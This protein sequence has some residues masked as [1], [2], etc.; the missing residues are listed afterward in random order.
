MRGVRGTYRK[1]NNI[2]VEADGRKFDS[3]KEYRR[4]QELKIL[5]NRGEIS[6][7]QCQVKFELAEAVREADTVGVR[8]GKIK[9]RVILPSVSYIADFVYFKDGKMIVEDTKSEA[10]KTPVYEVKKK[11]FYQKYKILISE[12]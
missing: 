2:K 12:V 8:G 6:N 9:G 1:Y 5:E 4:Y 7:L 3:K 11:W 10:T